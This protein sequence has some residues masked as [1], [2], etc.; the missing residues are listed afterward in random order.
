MAA[1]KKGISLHIGLNKIS[2]AHYGPQTPLGGCINDARDMAAV[3][4]AKGFG[5]RLV[6]TDAKATSKNVLK[7]I[8]DAA[9]TLAPGD[10]FFI[11]YSGHGSQVED[12]NGDNEE[13]GADETWC[14]YDRMLVDD[15]L[16]AGWGK[17]AAGV[18]ILM[19]SDS[20]HSGTMARAIFSPPGAFIPPPPP[21]LPARRNMAG[22]RGVRGGVDGDSVPM[23][24]L[25]P[26]DNQRRAFEGHRALYREIQKKTPTAARAAVA[27]SVILISGCQDYEESDD[28]ASNGRFTATLLKVYNGGKFK[29]GYRA[30]HKEI[31]R[32]MPDYQRPNFF[33]TGVPNAVFERQTPFQI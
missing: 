15:E 13:D 31:L 23:N 28:L 33:T 25:L 30:F 1:P 8:A 20:C 17:F 4:K 10:I 24:R 18:R 32:R 19:L 27:A 26:A 6:L 11:T 14:L 5:Q 3:A 7:A 29:K 22:R 9:E 2:T 12:D 21:G 16:Y